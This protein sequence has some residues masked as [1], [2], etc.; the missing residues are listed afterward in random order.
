MAVSC[1]VG[2]RLSSDATLLW[3]WYRPATT[4]LIGRLALEPPYATDAALKRQRKQESKKARKQ[5]KER[6][7]ERQKERN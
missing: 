5:E 6:K 3:L 7:K 2:C 1:S 4:A